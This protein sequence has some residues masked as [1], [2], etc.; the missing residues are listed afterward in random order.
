M[1]G[2]NRDEHR[3]GH[4]DGAAAMSFNQLLVDQPA[5]ETPPRR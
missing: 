2:T 3:S 1:V 4:E 5:P